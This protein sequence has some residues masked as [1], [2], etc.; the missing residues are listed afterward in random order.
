[1]LKFYYGYREIPLMAH[2]E[3]HLHI[4]FDTDERRILIRDL[5]EV[6][7]LPEFI[8]LDQFINLCCCLEE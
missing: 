8:P 7:R 4:D 3:F 2:L 5:L 1:M 6:K